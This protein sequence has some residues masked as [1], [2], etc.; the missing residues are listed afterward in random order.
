M[1]ARRDDPALQAHSPRGWRRW[2]TDLGHREP[3]RLAE[4]GAIL[5]GGFVAAL[6]FLYAFAL[7][8]YEVLDQQ[9]RSVDLA[10][11]SMLR[12]FISPQLTILAET[13][14]LFGS[15][16]VFVLVFALLG[17]FLFQRRWAA[18]VSLVLVAAG[19]QVLND[20]L[21]D[22]FHRTRPEPVAGFIAAQQFS[23]PSGHAMVSAAFYFYLAYL[24]WNLMSS[25]WR[26]V[27]AVGLAALVLLIGLSR[28]YLEA[29]YL[30]DVLAGYLSGL[31]WAD[32]VIV[33][34]RV[35]AARRFRS[36]RRLSSNPQTAPPALP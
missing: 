14:S 13:I 2:L 30:S 28:L 35:L 19:A 33:G 31:L 7:L 29:H 36:R 12:P 17:L 20:I 1:A 27:L 4:S 15:Q 23:F 32:T 11:V 10:T 34:S 5:V 25:R 8:A 24:V 6:V 18:T 22:L 26:V 21:K 9:T 16:I 3:A